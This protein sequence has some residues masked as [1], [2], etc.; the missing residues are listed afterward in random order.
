MRRR[1][2]AI[3]ALVALVAGA[4]GSD[5]DT[6]TTST[7][8]GSDTGKGAQ[9]IPIGMD[10]RTEGFA[11]SW[12]HFFPH[13]VKAH[14]GDTLEFTSKF[15][16]E[17]HTVAFG[18]LID[19]GLEAFGKLDPE[20][21]GPPPPDVQAVL[22]KIPFVFNEEAASPDDELFIQAASQP[23]YLA[24]EE[25]PTKEACAKDKQE[26]PKEITGKER[27]LSSGF[28]ADEESVSFKLSDDMAPGDYTFVCLVHGP[29]MTEK[30]TVV[31]K[32]TAIPTPAEVTME[33]EHHLQEFVAKVK[34]NADK[35]QTSTSAQAPAGGFPEDEEVPSA[36]INVFP[37]EIVVKA[38]EKV[39]WTIDGFHVI[40][41]NAP[42]DARPWLQFDD[43][44]A[45]VANK[46]SF[47]PAASPPIPEPPAPAEGASEDG[48]PPPLPVDAGTWDGRGFHN[49]GA[50]FSDGQ[51]VYSL[52]FSKPGT[53]KYLCLVHPDMEGSVKVT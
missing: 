43:A 19:E 36:G 12:I 48:P 39:T 14:P 18:T 13:E 32:S 53:Y 15:T 7:T 23:C 50:P 41:F 21:E 38:G 4:C 10:A 9:T 27:F 47:V 16:G 45:L 1:L 51:L 49:S 40:A 35:V 11:S 42:E 28:L 29:E 3:L 5:D 6:N 30:V 34:A 8:G 2:A 31:E 17:P 22:D 20:H 26:A 44:G 25:P 46:K 24:S 37:T 33:G 52:A